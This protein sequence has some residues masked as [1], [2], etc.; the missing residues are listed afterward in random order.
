MRKGLYIAFIILGVIAASL[1]AAHIPPYWG[2]FAVANLF[3]IAGV[4][5]LHRERQAA[6]QDNHRQQVR[7]SLLEPFRQLH[8]SVEELLAGGDPGPGWPEGEALEELFRERFL[9]IENVRSL[10]QL[11]LG[12]AQFID[13]STVLA[14]AERLINRAVSATIDGYP[15]EAYAAL[16]E[17]RPF[18]D[19]TVSQLEKLLEKGRKIKAS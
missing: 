9:E 2:R 4:L 5:G 3:I 12:T 19:Q 18:V 17:A 11:R 6:L 14:R 10:L 16:Q 15:E 7:Q 1:F 8:R 13:V